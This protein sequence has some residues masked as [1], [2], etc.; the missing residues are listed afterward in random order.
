M[1]MS[2]PVGWFDWNEVLLPQ[3]AMVWSVRSAQ[4]WLVSLNAGTALVRYDGEHR[5]P[6]RI[7]GGFYDV[8]GL[9]GSG[10][11]G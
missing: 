9:S 10:G 5:L 7:A 4:V 11:H 6:G 2:V 3:H 8:A 1:A